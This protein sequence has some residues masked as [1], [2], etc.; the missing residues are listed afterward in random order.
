MKAL[1]WLV[2]GVIGGLALGHF[3]NNDP[4]GRAILSEL[5]SAAREFIGGVTDGYNDRP[6]TK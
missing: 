4:R 5:D 2:T 1:F 3:M 6:N